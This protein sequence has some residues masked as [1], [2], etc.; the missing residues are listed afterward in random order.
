MGKSSTGG[1]GRGRAYRRRRS[2]RGLGMTLV[3][4]LGLL[5]W[6]RLKL[7]T[8]TPRM[9]YADP[10]DAAMI[11]PSEVA[12]TPAGKNAPTDNENGDR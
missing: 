11:D 3:L 7:V 1:M 8:A 2:F 9:V 10:R 12:K 5:L 6:A 4:M